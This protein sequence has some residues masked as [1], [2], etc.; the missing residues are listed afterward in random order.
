MLSQYY[1]YTA[2]VLKYPPHNSAPIRPPRGQS[3]SS[4][5]TSELVHGR[6]TRSLD[7]SK[8]S[9]QKVGA[10]YW[11]AWPAGGSCSKKVTRLTYTAIE[12]QAWHSCRVSSPCLESS[13]GLNSTYRFSLLSKARRIMIIASHQYESCAFRTI[14]RF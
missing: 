5:Q 10:D 11:E 9:V 1:C 13:L 4:F 14:H 7:W 8:P 3:K 6:S 2:I 12:S